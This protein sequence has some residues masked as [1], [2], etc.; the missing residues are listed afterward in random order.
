MVGAISIDAR[1]KA[2]IGEDFPE[3]FIS[4]DGVASDDIKGKLGEIKESDTT[5]KA[6]ETKVS[7]VIF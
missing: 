7:V 6:V 2:L 4:L 3:H 5:E 1:N